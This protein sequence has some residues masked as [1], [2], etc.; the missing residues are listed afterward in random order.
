MSRAE[1]AADAGPRLR[2]R[3]RHDRPPGPLLRAPVRLRHGPPGRRGDSLLA[4]PAGLPGIVRRPFA[5][6]DGR[7]RR[8][9]VPA[10]QRNPGP[11]D[12]L[13]D[14]G[15][16]GRGDRRRAAEEDLALPA[17]QRADRAGDRPGEARGQAPARD[18][19][20]GGGDARGRPP[21]P[22][23]R[24]RPEAGGPLVRGGGVLGVLRGRHG[25]LRVERLEAGPRGGRAGLPDRGPL[26]ARP[27]GGR[28]ARL[29]HA[30]G[31]VARPARH[32][33]AWRDPAEGPRQLR[34]DVRRPGHRRDRPDD[35]IPGAR[36]PRLRRPGRLATPAGRPGGRR[37]RGRGRASPPRQADRGSPDA[38]EG[39]PGSRGRRGR[40]GSSG[41]ASG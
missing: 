7:L 14:P 29:G 11:G 20:P 34:P 27:L 16:G 2:R 24:D 3:T 12:P 9:A 23:R 33:L 28:D 40:S 13:P 32:E 26:A 38:L 10:P 36:R 17:G 39:V 41:P 18:G 4:D 30:D 1:T 25:D 37:R 19:D 21:D 35:R 6:A 31:R 5:E 22:L 8:R 15:L